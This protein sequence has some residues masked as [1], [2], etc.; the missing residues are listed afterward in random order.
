[1][2]HFFFQISLNAWFWSTVFH[3]RDFPLTELFD[4]GFAYSM[5]LSGLY[6]FTLRIL[7]RRS[8]LVKTLVTI[9]FTYY[10]L[11]HFAY[12]SIGKFDYSYNMKANIITGVFSSIGWI[13]W[14]IRNRRIKT[15]SW[16]IFLFHLLVG[17]TVLLELNDFPPIFWIFDAHSIWHLSTVPITILFYR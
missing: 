13:F 15:Y 11:N 8:N 7:H 1:M 10:F 9:L 17:A 14:Y 4:Y 16:K 5:V 6:C 12:L 2:K 3:T